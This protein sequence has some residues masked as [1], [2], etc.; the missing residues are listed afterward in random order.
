MTRS[1]I[2][3]VSYAVAIFSVTMATPGNAKAADPKP[4]PGA[5]ELDAIDRTGKAAYEEG[6]YAFC[7]EPNTP[8]GARQKGLCE[9]AS[10]IDGCEGLQKACASAQQP[11]E[12]SWLERLTAWAG[13]I[14]KGL[15]YLLVLGIIVALVVPVVR[16]ILQLRRDRKIEGTS[17]AARN[18][19]VVVDEKAPHASEI[20]DAETALE[21]AD[22]H[23]ARG[24]LA[25]A[26]GLYLTASLA[27]LDRR[28]ALRIARYRTN[29]EYVRA[30]EEE[31]S[32]RALREIVREVDA[33]EFGGAPATHEGVS[34]VASRAQSIVRATTAALAVIAALALG[35]SPARP[36]AD[37]AGDELPIEILRRN[38]FHVGR[39]MSS[40][41]TMPIPDEHEGASVV[42]VDVERVAL[43][44]EAQA[45][46]MRWVEAGGVLVLF[47]RVEA[48]PLELRP[49]AE[50]AQTRDLVVRT[51]DPNGGL[52]DLDSDE[53]PE[54]I[55]APV[56]IDGARIARPDAFVWDGSEALGF[57]GDQAYA[58]KRRVG[59]GL[60]LGV[61]NDD[62]FTNVGARPRRNAAALVTLVRAASHDPMRRVSTEIGGISMLGDVRVARAEDG[63][64]PPANPFAALLAAGL[65][66]GAW[67]ALVAAVLLFLAYGIRHAR[68]RP[69]DKETRRA[70]AEHVEATG[71]LY[72]RARAHAHALAAYGRFVELRVREKRADDPAE[73]LAARSGVDRARAA[74][75]Y[76]RATQAKPGD[77]P[78]GDELTI[79]EELRRMMD[80]DARA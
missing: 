38:G 49:K 16:A 47:G 19:A 58:A 28:G 2:V 42:I 51:P 17:P 46:V 1:T 54:M 77:A 48:W 37:P 33:V 74:E 34:R 55:G 12:T 64:P 31:Q 59:K 67:H 5:H 21:L 69:E 50:R 24:E 40:L 3:R 52:E 11:K 76:A 25:R 8:L 65:G 73:F 35:C 71:A 18:H 68:A 10:E 45:H 41:A 60:V 13:P 39:L 15:L 20:A 70:F 75:L 66:K 44:D 9:L 29:G 72:H 36:G 6:A 4:T 32:K 80:D 61:A 79:I 53:G 22:E 7:K 27:A 57:L 30:C 63:I 43:Q 62:L 56:A 26:L 23:R 78:R 14:A